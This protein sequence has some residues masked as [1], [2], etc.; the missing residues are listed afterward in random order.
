[1]P[2]APSVLRWRAVLVAGDEAQAVF[3]N[4]IVW[5]RDELAAIGVREERVRMLSA[6]P[7]NI[8]GGA[9]RASLSNLRKA[10]AE[11]VRGNREGC[12]LFLTSH[13]RQ[14]GLFLAYHRE[15]LA[16]QY[17]DGV[18]S[19]YCSA[20]PTVVIVSAC[21][22]GIFA[23]EAMQ[24]PNRIILTASRPDRRSF[25]CTHNRSYTF[26]DE[27]LLD[28][29]RQASTWPAVHDRITRCVAAKEK[30]RPKEEPSEP[31]SFAGAEVAGMPA[32]WA[33]VAPAALT[34]QYQFTPGPAYDPDAVPVTDAVRKERRAALERYA[35]ASEPK[36]FAVTAN[37]A[38]FGWGSRDGDQRRTLDDV[39]RIALQFC[40]WINST[41]C[42]LYAVNDRA[43]AQARGEGLPL[44][45]PALA[46]WGVFDPALVPFVRED[47]RT[48]AAG[49]AALPRPKAVAINPR[50]DKPAFGI[51]AGATPGQA[52]QEALSACNANARQAEGCV[53]FA[54]DE[55]IVLGYR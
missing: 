43:L 27:C 46:R 52:Q 32:P 4:A 39:R 48:R 37:G 18:L 16:P 25:G 26:Y 14:N 21:Y 8:A 50:L 1:M 5:M 47:E 17:L 35:A 15:Y 45:A 31:Q 30:R 34:L 22:S 23:G 55:Q 6:T 7:A 12:F 10:V 44:H 2:E 29:L 20:R 11:G 24:K 19:E 38:G 13:G 9:E 49:Y 51:S 42:V 40:E 36:A 28:G 54:E 3:D 33:A 53:L 41:R